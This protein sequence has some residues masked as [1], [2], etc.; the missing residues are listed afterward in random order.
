MGIFES[1]KQRR[2]KISGLCEQVDKVIDNS[3]AYITRKHNKFIPPE[4]VLEITN[5]SKIP[6][7]WQYHNKNGKKRSKS[8]IK[9]YWMYKLSIL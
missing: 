5:K 7:R 9:V 4:W 6:M 3:N 1:F 2:N 8:R